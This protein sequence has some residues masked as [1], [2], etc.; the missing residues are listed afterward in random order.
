MFYST[1][2]ESE[3]QFDQTIGFPGVYFSANKI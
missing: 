2:G 1:I 3:E